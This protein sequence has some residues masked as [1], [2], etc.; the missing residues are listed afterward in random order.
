MLISFNFDLLRCFTRKIFI[1]K[2]AAIK[3]LEYSPLGSEFEKQIDFALK[4]YQGLDK[5]YGFDKKMNNKRKNK[6]ILKHK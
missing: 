6:A 3:I 2:A 1:K 5:I 4:Q